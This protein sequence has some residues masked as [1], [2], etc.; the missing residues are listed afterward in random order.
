MV[1]FIWERPWPAGR[2]TK[3]KP[4]HLERCLSG[5]ILRVG[6]LILRVGGLI[7][8]VGVL[9]FKNLSCLT[10]QFDLFPNMKTLR[11]FFF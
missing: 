1:S 11:S 3:S 4:S 8:R 2:P 6:G 7:L 5:L 9:H 10:K